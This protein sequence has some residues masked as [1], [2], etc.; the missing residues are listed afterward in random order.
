[1]DAPRGLV[2]VAD[3]FGIGPAVSRALLELGSEGR[4]AASVLLVNSPHASE[5]VREWHRAGG[6][7]CLELGWHVC[8]TMDFPV[9]PAR[10]VPS[11][12]DDTGRFLTLGRLLARL[13]AGRIV[14]SEVQAELKAQHDRFCQLTGQAPLVVN[15]HHHVHV[16]PTVARLLPE[17]LAEQNPLPYVRREDE[18][19]AMLRAVPRARAKR[20]F[21]TALGRRCLSLFERSGFPG[22]ASLVGTTDA[23][24]LAGIGDGVANRQLA[25]WLSAAPGPV[26]ELMCH[27]GKADAALK[28]GDGAPRLPRLLALLLP[29]LKVA[30]EEQARA[31]EF[32]LLQS[33]AVEKIAQSA[34]MTLL[35]SHELFHR[36]QLPQA[37]WHPQLR[38]AASGS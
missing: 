35:R 11:L 7:R 31:R 3:D 19:F 14:A 27:P 10:A 21:L 30:C 24:G 37:A 4:I 12:V 34:G 13:A 32:A 18:T 23:L 8:L 38:Q 22:N 9:L 15:G 17:L 20:L 36:P 25:A 28:R 6:A 33:G 2:V 1:M 29:G 5:S 16:F 26:V